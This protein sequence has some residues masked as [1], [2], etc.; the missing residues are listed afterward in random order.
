MED[1]KKINNDRG[2]KRTDS[3]KANQLGPSSPYE[4]SSSHPQS[5]A[6]NQSAD[7]DMDRR[8]TSQDELKNDAEEAQSDGNL[9]FP[10]GK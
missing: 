1:N 2:F 3:D 7:N 10:E 5:D 9:G 6:A 8:T 4:K